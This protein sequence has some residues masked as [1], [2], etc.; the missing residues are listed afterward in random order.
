[1]RP[2]T[3][4]VAILVPVS[5]VTTVTVGARPLEKEL[6]PKG[7]ACFERLYDAAHLAA[8][9]KQEVTR[10]A[11]THDRTGET[12]SEKDAP[13]YLEVEINVRGK[14]DNFRLG[15]FCAVQGQAL[16]CTPEWDAGTFTVQAAAGG[17]LTVT[18]NK[19]V[20]NPDNFDA[21]EVAPGAITLKGDDKVWKLSP[22]G[23]QCGK[24]DSSAPTPAAK[25]PNPR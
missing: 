18:N 2:L 3:L 10:I 6:P 25:V 1:M 24:Q 15:G 9:P 8:H 16:L 5:L 21:E 17:G 23:P 4:L 7:K 11:V 20:F 14:A 19:M 22:G 12:G 13:L